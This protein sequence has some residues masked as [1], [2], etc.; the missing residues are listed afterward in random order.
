MNKLT[1]NIRNLPNS[2]GVYC[3][4]LKGDIVYVGSSSNIRAR[5]RGHIGAM[6]NGTNNGGLNKL[7][8]ENSE[9]DFRFSVLY[10]GEDYSLKEMEYIVLYRPICNS[11]V[12]IYGSS[13]RFKSTVA[14]YIKRDIYD[15]LKEMA[16]RDTRDVGNFIEA[17]YIFGHIEKQP[18]THKKGDIREDPSLYGEASV[19]SV[20]GANPKG[21][22][23][24]TTSAS[25]GGENNIGSFYGGTV[26]YASA[27][28]DEAISK[29]ETINSD[30]YQPTSEEM[31]ELKRY[32]KERNLQY[33]PMKRTLD[34]Y[35]NGKWS[36][37][38]KFN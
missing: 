6:R 28:Y 1:N 15:S 2:A 19:V 25:L 34:K 31:T 32:L 3:I 36:V 24:R 4:K 9:E 13:S 33:N 35:E 10:K 26:G 21:L 27:N 17:Q 16:D 5:A 22:E 29:I 37:V 8:V 14:V 30:G 23:S 20:F 11:E 18:A 7:W 38:H 12:G